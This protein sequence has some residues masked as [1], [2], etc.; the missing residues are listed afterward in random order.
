[1]ATDKYL[2]KILVIALC[3]LFGADMACADEKDKSFELINSNLPG[4][5]LEKFSAKNLVDQHDIN[6]L[7]IQLR[8]HAAL[9]IKYKYL[10]ITAPTQ[11]TGGFQF[12]ITPISKN[13]F[14]I[15][16]RSPPP[17]AA[18]TMGMSTPIALIKIP[19]YAHISSQIKECS[20][21]KD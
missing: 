11:R 16:L 21:P 15:C 2:N 7:P 13:Q 14:N 12:E 6:S 10:Y 3:S 17:M 18:V 5:N 8:D 1:M 4:T 9:S 19:K 20:A